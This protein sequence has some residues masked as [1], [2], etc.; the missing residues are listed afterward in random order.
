[1]QC[2]I[3]SNHIIYLYMH[4]DVKL[5]QILLCMI[6]LYMYKGESIQMRIFVSLGATR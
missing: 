5:L 1:M 3:T 2:Y 4:V 6:H